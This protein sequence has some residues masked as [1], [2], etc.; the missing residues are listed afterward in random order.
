MA[1]VFISHRGSD[2]IEAERLANEI[3]RAGHQVWLDTG[4]LRVDEADVRGA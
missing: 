1:N 4:D 2:T 3:R